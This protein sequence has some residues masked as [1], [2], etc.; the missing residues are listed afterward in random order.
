MSHCDNQDVSAVEPE[1]NVVRK[2]RHHM[3][4]KSSHHFLIGK[5]VAANSIDRIRDV[6][7]KASAKPLRTLLVPILSF[8]NIESG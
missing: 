6:L 4:A 8:C 7:A 1:P 3:A 5:R 2:A